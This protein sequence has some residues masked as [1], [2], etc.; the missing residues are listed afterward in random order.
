MADAGELVIFA[1]QLQQGIAGGHQRFVSV[2]RVILQLHI[3][4]GGAAQT[5]DG[6]RTAGKDAR[7][8]NFVKRFGCAFDDGKR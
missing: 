1:G 7:F 2:A 6:R 4:T 3:E 5:A 8:F